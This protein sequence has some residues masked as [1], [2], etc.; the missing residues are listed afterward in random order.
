[1]KDNFAIN[2]MFDNHLE[3]K[4]AYIG[5]IYDSVFNLATLNQ[6]TKKVTKKS[7]K[8]T[9]HLLPTHVYRVVTR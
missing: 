2:F 3:T 7:K 5:V 9:E 8:F 6:P 4:Q 1:M